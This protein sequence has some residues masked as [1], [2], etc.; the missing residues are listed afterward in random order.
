MNKD[1]WVV[2]FHGNRSLISE[3]SGCGEGG[4][5]QVMRAGRRDHQRNE[6]RNKYDE[7]SEFL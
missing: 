2:G 4:E 5:E 1:M 7:G 6:H 3:L